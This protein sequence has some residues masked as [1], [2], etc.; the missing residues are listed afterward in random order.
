[1]EE[2]TNDEI[3]MTMEVR[4]PNDETDCVIPASSFVML[5]SFWFRHSTFS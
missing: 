4:I 2:M 3:R 5:S 1:M